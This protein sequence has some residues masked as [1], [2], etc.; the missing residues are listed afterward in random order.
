MAIPQRELGKTGVKVSALAMGGHHLGDAENYEMAERLVHDALDGG[1]TVFDNCWEYHDGKSEVWLGRALA[2]GR[3]DKAFV[4][5]KVCTHGRDADL[6]MRMLEESLRRLRTDHLDLWQ[7]HGMGFDNDPDRAYRKG[8]VLEALEQAKKQGKVRFVGFTGHKD[9]KVHARMLSMGF[10]F[11]TVQMP[12]NA[13]DGT[14]R[15]FETTVIP[16]AQKRGVSVIGMKPLC[17]TA[18]PVKK[19]LVSSEELLRYAMSLPVL[20]TVTGIEKPD[21]LAKGLAVARDFKPMSPAEMDALRAKCR[22][23][24]A[25]GRYELY[26]VSLKYDNPNARIPHGF[27]VDPVQKEVAEEQKKVMGG[28]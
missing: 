26:K 10:P 15:S 22:T 25:D 21:I 8:G 7:I 11:D 14:F 9:P 24:A 2:G 19:G 6:G 16:E 23:V 20:T 17:G 1:I 18:T 28:P 13:F 3:R 12:L 5:T 4:M 27:P